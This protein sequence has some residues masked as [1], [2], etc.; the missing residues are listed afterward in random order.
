MALILGGMGWTVHRYGTRGASVAEQLKR[1][2]RGAAKWLLS[3]GRSSHVPSVRR[4]TRRADKQQCGATVAG[5]LADIWRR[6][7]VR[8]HPVLRNGRAT[9]LLSRLRGRN[10]KELYRFPLAP[11][12]SILIVIVYSRDMVELLSRCL[13]ISII[14][15][16]GMGKRKNSVG[17]CVTTP[18]YFCGSLNSF[19]P[20]IQLNEM[21]G[22]ILIPS[23]H[24]A[25]RPSPDLTPIWQ[26]AANTSIS[27]TFSGLGSFRSV[28][29]FLARLRVNIGI[30]GVDYLY[31]I[32]VKHR[33]I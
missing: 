29:H 28:P 19:G 25:A 15:G 7:G 16:G 5:W 21:E 11:S 17:G 6:R 13:R 2:D 14:S 4:Q 27:V 24:A 18:E 32:T 33:K 30:Y 9:I 10:G 3:T 8:S 20:D 1:T 26:S 31:A 23:S 22:T 12:R